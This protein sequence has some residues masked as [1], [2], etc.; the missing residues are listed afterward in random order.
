MNR[1]KRKRFVLIAGAAVFCVAVILSVLYF[2]PPSPYIRRYPS[3]KENV[4]IKVKYADDSQL[5]NIANCSLSKFIEETWW[6]NIADISKISRAKEVRY[7]G[8][9]NG[10]DFDYDVSND[11]IYYSVYGNAQQK[12]YVFYRVYYTVSATKQEISA[13][14]NP[15]PKI[16]YIDTVIYIK[17][18]LT[19]SDFDSLKVGVSTDSDVRKIDPALTTVPDYNVFLKDTVDTVDTYYQSCQ[20]LGN[21]I[22]QYFASDYAS[23]HVTKDGVIYIEYTLKDNIYTVSKIEK[24]KDP[25]IDMINPL[26]MTDPSA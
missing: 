2:L 1:T 8:K 22:G 18:W 21:S 11:K 14:L 23:W 6:K 25:Y 4:S 19:Y 7:A 16:A 17:K 13:K 5:N 9:L 3:A 20:S 24:I 10:G 15:D 26:D 12:M